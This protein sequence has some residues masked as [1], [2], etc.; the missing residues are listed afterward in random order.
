[1]N[2]QGE[3]LWA[4][5]PVEVWEN[6][7]RTPA[8]RYRGSEMDRGQP[9][10]AVADLLRNRQGLANNSLWDDLAALFLMRPELFAVRG[11][12]SSPAFLRQPFGPT[13]RQP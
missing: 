8:D 6:D 9:A 5:A 3:P 2:S 4:F 1:M 10:R 12:M 11:A 13:Y 7:L